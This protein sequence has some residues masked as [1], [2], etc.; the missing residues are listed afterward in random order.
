MSNPTASRRR[1]SGA[2][3]PYQLSGLGIRDFPSM[4]SNGKVDGKADG[5]QEVVVPASL[6]QDLRAVNETPSPKTRYSPRVTNNGSFQTPPSPGMLYPFAQH[7]SSLSKFKSQSQVPSSPRLPYDAQNPSTPTPR[8]GSFGSTPGASFSSDCSPELPGRAPYSRRP[9][10]LRTPPTDHP[11]GEVTHL[12]GDEQ[13]DA[14]EHHDEEDSF[15]PDLPMSPAR[16]AFTNQFTK[17]DPAPQN[18][19]SSVFT[20]DPF[21]D[22][23]VLEPLS[24]PRTST[25]HTRNQSIGEPRV[26]ARNLSLFFPQPG[27]EILRAPGSPRPGELEAPVTDISGQGRRKAGL[28]AN[29]SFSFGS[30]NQVLQ[31]PSSPIPKVV[32]RRG[33]HV[34]TD[35]FVTEKWQAH[36]LNCLVISTNIHFPTTFSPSSI[37][38]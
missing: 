31:A 3:R 30:G 15:L 32:G 13:E 11:T 17:P 24:T 25:P 16:F 6:G 26:H 9:T 12:T 35:S 23:A 29:G 14:Q 37:L 22:G 19:I 4:Q 10:L 36:L 1:S 27:A 20:S 21:S 34:S 33:H 8:M 38:R 5:E 2:D 28:G 18:S 7:G